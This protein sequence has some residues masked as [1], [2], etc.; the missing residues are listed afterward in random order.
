MNTL[1]LWLTLLMQGVPPLPNQGGTV[2]GIVKSADGTPAANVRVVAMV[3]P[4]SPQDVAGIASMATLAE[5]DENGR[6]RLDNVPLGRYLIA[7]GRIDAQTY[8]PGFLDV[9]KASKVL[10]T[11]GNTLTGIN[12]TLNDSSGGRASNSGFALVSSL[13]S[14][15]VPF[16]FSGTK[17]PI[18]YPGGYP[19]L[20]LTNVKNGQRWTAT[21]DRLSINVGPTQGSGSSSESYNVSIEDFPAGYS[22][23]SMTSG[24]VDL[25]QKPF[26]IPA[27]RFSTSRVVI[28][29]SIQQALGLLN[30]GAVQPQAPPPSP[31]PVPNAS[32]IVIELNYAAPPAPA[33][34]I[35][36]AG[37]F[38]GN[39][40]AR[41]FYISN[42]QGTTYSDG[43]FE[44]AGVPPGRHVITSRNNSAGANPLG[45][46]LVV[47]GR[48]V[49]DVKLE[50]FA[51]LPMEFASQP[52]SDTRPAGSKLPLPS[53]NGRVVD[54]TTGT[55][56]GQ[57]VVYFSGQEMISFRLQPDGSF[58]IPHLLPGSYKLEIQVFG[59]I[60]VSRDL[61]IADEN[62][63]IEF[64]SAN[65]FAQ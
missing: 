54:Q 38:N 30:S 62:L 6:Y 20:V 61:V 35:R 25:A 58:Q 31:A 17:I 18:S 47:G 52:Q 40:G 64:R 42:I 41:S 26:Q 10:V 53:L 43:T 60:N 24:P 44:F 57:G 9:A 13:P 37:K 14:A 36:V 33:T 8:Y 27:G 50:E 11:A 56:I 4:D 7:A 59:H 29:V 5:T 22:I 21:M 39:I 2:T 1:L 28:A 34:G 3:P 32:S 55:G 45:A 16:K 46:V 65:F 48:D 12:F 23:K 51:V 19:K 49:E 15:D 63:D